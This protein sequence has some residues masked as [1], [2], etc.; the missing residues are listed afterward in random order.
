VC[1][2]FRFLFFLKQTTKPICIHEVVLRLETK[3][4]HTHTHTQHTHE[5]KKQPL[6]KKN[7]NKEKKR[8][9]GIGMLRVDCN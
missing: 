2:F 3:I 4:S 6:K 5:K 9:C 1:M 8:S 7:T